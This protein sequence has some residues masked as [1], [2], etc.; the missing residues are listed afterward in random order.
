MPLPVT[1]V[2]AM[3]FSAPLST[4][5]QL[6]PVRIALTVVPLEVVSSLVPVRLTLAPLVMVGASLIALTVKLAVSVA[7]E[8]ALLPP[9]LL[10]SAVPPFVPLV[11]SQARKVI[12]VA[13]VPLKLAL[14]WK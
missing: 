3:P 7:L 12:A 4:S 8:N 1:A 13:S 5:A 14:G 2:T 9:L 11:R 6:A 10:V